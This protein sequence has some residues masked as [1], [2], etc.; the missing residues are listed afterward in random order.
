[1]RNAGKIAAVLSM[2][3]ALSAV[4]GVSAFATAGLEQHCDDER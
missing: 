2:G 4:C 1:M 3:M